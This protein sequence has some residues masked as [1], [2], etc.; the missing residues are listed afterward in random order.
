MTQAIVNN[1]NILDNG[2]CNKVNQKSANLTSAVSGEKTSD[3]FNKILDKTIDKDSCTLGD[4]KKSNGDMSDKIKNFKNILIQATREVNMEKSLDL[5][6]A[7]DI[8]EIIDQLKAAIN[9]D[10]SEDE[11][12]NESDE[13]TDVLNISDN[14]NVSEIQIPAE[15]EHVFEQVL[16]MINTLSNIENPISNNIIQEES[17]DIELPKTSELNIM[18]EINKEEAVDAESDSQQSL[19]EDMLSELK[20]EIVDSQTGSQSE[21]NMTQ[22]ETPEEVGIKIMLNHGDEKTDVQFEKQINL[23]TTKPVEITS[24][25]IIEQIT[26]HLDSLK[27]S[28]KLTMTLNPETL[29]KINLQIL[30]S[31]DGLSAQ[32]TVM[33][34]D[35][36]ELLMKGL[37]GLKEALLAQGVNVDNI[38]IKVSD[39]K[40]P[41]NPDWTEQ[42][43]SEKNNKEQQRQKQDEKEKGLFEKTITKSLNKENGNV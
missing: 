36:R 7:R 22:Q 29:G 4:M 24:E 9:E 26:K 1:F 13:T 33:T 28:S 41:Y 6:L 42:E 35:A 15:N 20:V 25:K 14:D 34:N 18:P 43:N 38:S 39:A 23:N 5:T 31:K 16:T 32:L 10:L 11:S 30:N 17:V 19:D 21:E 27:T 8:T 3:N 37:T 2:G 12:D 40:E